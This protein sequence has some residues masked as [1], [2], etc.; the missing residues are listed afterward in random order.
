MLSGHLSISNLMLDPPITTRKLWSDTVNSKFLPLEFHIRQQEGFSAQIDMLDRTW[1]LAIV[2]TQAHRVCRTRHLA[3]RADQGFFKVFWLLDGHCEIEQGNNRA[4][5]NPGEWALYDTTR[6]YAIEFGH[7]TQF[8]VFLL[9]Y[10]SCSGWQAISDRICGC[11]LPIDASSH[12]ALFALISMFDAPVRQPTASIAP[13][14]DAAGRML[15]ASV[16]AWMERNE[17]SA[18]RIRLPEAQRYV[19]DHIGDASLTPERLASALN[20]SR[21]TL[22]AGFHSHGLTPASF[23]LETRLDRCRAALIDPAHHNHTIT[24]IALD[25]GFCDG[26]HFSRLFKARY[27][28]TPRQW[29]ESK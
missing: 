1:Q 17:P 18:G 2:R 14:I 26:A 27:G 11:S 19:L 6:P 15:S 20:V 4:L 23:I 22:Y 21:R 12:G 13:V 28:V 29:R 5:L 9:P 3:E 16:L 8:L 10:T 24:Q 7:D 25:H